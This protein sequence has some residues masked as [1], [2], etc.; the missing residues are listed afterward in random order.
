MSEE[1]PQTELQKRTP[2]VDRILELAML[3]AQAVAEEIVQNQSRIHVYRNCPRKYYW[4][5]VEN[6]DTDRPA[7]NLEVGS[8]THEGLAQLGA[9]KSVDEAVESAK[10]AFRAALPK[11]RLPGDDE[12]YA[13]SEAVVE[14]LLR[15]YEEHWG[16]QSEM[17]RPLGNE[18]AGTVEVA[19]D[20]LP[21]DPNPEVKKKL[22]F[23]TDKFV[24]AFG[25]LWIV[26]HKTAAKMDP[27]TMMQYQMDL[28]MTAYIYGAMKLLETVIG[29][30]IVDFLV[31]T[32]VP[33]FAREA[34]ERTEAE[35]NEFEFNWT[36]WLSRIRQDTLDAVTIGKETGKPWLAF[37]RNE[38][39]C[40][41][42]GTCMF[43]SLC[44]DPANMG[45]RAE[46]V[47]REKDYVDDPKL[48]EDP[49][50]QEQ[51]PS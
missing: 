38:A 33:Q 37:P 43:R 16:S 24:H 34:F 47:Q 30:V 18:V 21:G 8:A 9:G 50:V 20:P 26:D 3:A 4:K 46:F 2:N 6:L 12:L 51:N 32:K 42:Y 5:F 45:L 25:G 19:E 31:K 36:R 44:G 13:E 28:Q 10:Q 7:M 29:G 14:N 48:L 41:R 11:R 22:R 35:L 40:F 27:R 15:S 49:K 23:K 39:E 1:H 17:F